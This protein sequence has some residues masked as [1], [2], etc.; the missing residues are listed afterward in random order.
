[1][2][3]PVVILA[4]LVAASVFG[5]STSSNVTVRLGPVS[6]LGT[7]TNMWFD[8]DVTINNQTRVPLA[9]TNLF[10]RLPGLALK[11]TDLD[12]R[13]LKRTHAWPLKS[14][15]WTH[16]PGS[17][18]AKVRRKTRFGSLRLLLRIGTEI[19]LSLSADANESVLVVP[20]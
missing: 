7:H 8:C 12:N 19:S 2:K 5:D 11:I 4:L 16:A 13:E 6:V 9:V 17:Q 3:N 14:W 18:K 10:V 20:V 1:M 15:E